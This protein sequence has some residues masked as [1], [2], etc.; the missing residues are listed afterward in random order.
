MNW[1]STI[2]LLI[3]AAAAGVWLW[4][5]DEWVPRLAPKAAPPDQPALVAF[6][7]DFTPK[8]L[9]R[10]EIAPPD[11]DAFVFTKTGN[12]WAQPGN[13]PLRAIE[14]N[15]LIELLGTLHTRF[16]PVPLP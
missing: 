1:K 16:Q 12:D 13:W 3:L 4:K 11:S 15:E 9:T 10:I 6:E 14:L 5:G 2:L 8:T 7:A